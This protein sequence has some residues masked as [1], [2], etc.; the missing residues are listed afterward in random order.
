LPNCLAV[1]FGA[2]LHAVGPAGLEGN[3][4]ISTIADQVMLL[5]RTSTIPIVVLMAS[6][7]RVVGR[8]GV[9]SSITSW[10]E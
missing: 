6:C 1:P 2:G 8:Y 3:S 4:H 9:T 10:S 5:A 7:R